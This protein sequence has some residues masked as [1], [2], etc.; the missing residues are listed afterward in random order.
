MLVEP[1]RSIRSV[2]EHTNPP[3]LS[4]LFNARVSDDVDATVIAARSGNLSAQSELVCRYRRRV[5]GLL[6]SMVFRHSDLEELVQVTFI[7]MSR[8]LHLL[9]DPGLFKSWI[10]TLARN[11]AIDHMR[12]Q[13]RERMVLVDEPALARMEVETADTAK[14]IMEAFEIALTRIA[15]IDQ[16]LLRM[17]IHGDSYEA[18]AASTGLSVVVIKGR[19]CRVRPKLKLLLA[20]AATLSD[21][22]DGKGQRRGAA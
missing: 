20:R 17:R 16:T 13:R 5:G 2:D 21:E 18:I 8:Q 11:T 19:L 10:F 15:P 3:M 12:Q 9:R 22:G 4:Q 1:S 6:K 14:D 7:K